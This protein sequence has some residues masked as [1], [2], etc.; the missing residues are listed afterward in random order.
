M[1]EYEQG[2]SPVW[3]H[4]EYP[5]R[6]QQYQTRALVEWFL[7]MWAIHGRECWE[8]KN[9]LQV[10]SMVSGTKNMFRSL[11]VQ[12]QRLWHCWHYA[13]VATVT[14]R[15]HVLASEVTY[16]FHQLPPTSTNFFNKFNEDSKIRRSF[17]IIRRSFED[18][19]RL[20]W[21]RSSITV[22]ESKLRKR[23]SLHLNQTFTWF[24][25]IQN[26]YVYIDI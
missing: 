8:F 20:R 26:I 13:T 11:T 5:C 22:S 16:N 12:A 23:L 24:I 15:W 7:Q 9:S 1:C 6:I 18:T 21:K 4:L 17:G 3:S 25:N 2:Y 10:S 14:T 19:Q